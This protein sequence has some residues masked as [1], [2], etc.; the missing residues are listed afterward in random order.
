MRLGTVLLG[1]VV[2]V[3][4]LVAGVVA[5]VLTIDPNESQNELVPL[6]RGTTGRVWVLGGDISL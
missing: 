5:L 4:A 1:F 2:L 6:V 3:V